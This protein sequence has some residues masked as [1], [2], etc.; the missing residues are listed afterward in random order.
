MKYFF[1][2]FLPPVAVLLCGRPFSAILNFLFTLCG[3]IP[4]TIHAV[5]L[6]QSYEANKRNERL[7]KAINN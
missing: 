1:A 4:G 2:I 6:V 3:W 5:L 7:I